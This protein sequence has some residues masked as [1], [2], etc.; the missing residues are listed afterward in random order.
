MCL[1]SGL[2]DGRFLSDRSQIF[3]DLAAAAPHDLRERKLHGHGTRAS[4]SR[5]RQ[6]RTAAAVAGPGEPQPEVQSAAALPALGNIGTED[7]VLMLGVN[8]G[9]MLSRLHSQ[10]AIELF[11][12]DTGYLI[13]CGGDTARQIVNAG[14]GFANV[15]HLFVTHHHVDHTAGIPELVTLGW[16]FR[17]NDQALEQL[18]IWGPPPVAS[19]LAH[20]TGAYE[21]GTHL[22]E[23]AAGLPPWSQVTQAHELTL[24]LQGVTKVMEDENVVVHAARVF[25]GPEIR[26][27]YAYRFDI[28]RTRKSVVFSGDTAGPNRQLIALA[29]SADLLVH[30]VQMDS[31][32]PAVL[33]AI[34]PGMRKGFASHLRSIHTDVTVVPS[35]A[36]AAGAKRLA[37]CHYALEADPA[38]F[39]GPA[40]NAAASV[41]YGGEILAPSELDQIPV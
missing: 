31:N 30:E 37:F 5:A 38:A 28:K 13:D 33:Q 36:K 19:M 20:I 26:D 39:L 2:A 9:P 34:A 8:G 1:V 6:P 3:E 22:F 17:A 21:F 41:S 40:K 10:P 11:V 14:G 4:T 25:H 32:I 18:T 12:N 16:C 15:R 27:A 35:V 7:R 24:P 23:V 29:E